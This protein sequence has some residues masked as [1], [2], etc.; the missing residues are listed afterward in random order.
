MLHKVI[1]YIKLISVSIL[2]TLANLLVFVY[3]LL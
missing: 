1:N 3:K 2:I